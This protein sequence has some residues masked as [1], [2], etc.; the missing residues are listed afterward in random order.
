MGHPDTRGAR[1]AERQRA[2]A[3]R[4]N[5]ARNAA[6]GFD[7]GRDAP[8]PGDPPDLEGW[9][10]APR[11]AKSKVLC[12]CHYCKGWL[13]PVPRWRWSGFLDDRLVTPPTLEGVRDRLR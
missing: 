7:P 6:I 10:V 8:R 9:P 2:I 4:L 11:L 5:W 3:R 1:R 13:S 12:T